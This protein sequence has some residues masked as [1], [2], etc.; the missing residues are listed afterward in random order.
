M[1]ACV[2]DNMQPGDLFIAAEWGWPDYLSYFHHRSAANLINESA[3]FSDK[4]G[5]LAAIQELIEETRATRGN[6][7]ISD[8]RAFSETHLEWLRDTTGITHQD[9][10]ALGGVPAFRCDGRTIFKL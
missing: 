6:V 3:S 2:A 9:L 5:T 10:L 8:P 1:A 4:Q 7:Y